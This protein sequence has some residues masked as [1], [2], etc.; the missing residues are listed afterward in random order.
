MATHAPIMGSQTRAPGID[1]R[2]LLAALAM[3]PII[4]LPTS[5]ALGEGRAD[6][7][8]WNRALALYEAALDAERRYARTVC[9]PMEAA[10]ARLSP[11]PALSF[12]APN[13]P[14]TSYILPANKL[15]AYDRHPSPV[16]RR[17]AAQVRDAW[18]RHIEARRA[19]NHDAINEEWE[20][21]DQIADAAQ[22]ALLTM[23][24]PDGA[25]LWWK[26][27]QLFGKGGGRA[28]DDDGNGW[29]AEVVNA[30]MADAKR[31]LAGS[32]H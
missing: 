5:A 16:V 13:M 23:P 10:L 26:L 6:C 11:R 20:R 28:E 2:K 17:A 19:V 29:S 30:F 15:A 24:A 25:A 21:L 12:D 7:G 27:D 3:S 8:A 9:G 1:R 14:G 32:V 4:A 31:L 18:L 22:Y